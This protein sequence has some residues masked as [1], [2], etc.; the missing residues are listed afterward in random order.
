M[1]AA[2]AAAPM[3]DPAGP[4]GASPLPRATVGDTYVFDNPQERWTVVAVD[5]DRVTW[6]S[7][8]GASRVTQVDPLMPSIESA[9][10]GFG[11]VT[12]I[13]QSQTGALWPLAVGNESSFVVAVGMEQPPYS[14][15]LAWN[16]RVVGVSRIDVEA[17]TFNTHKVACAR[18]DG[19][20]LN[21]Y[22]APT[23]GYFVRREVTTADQQ[24]ETR[25]LVSFDNA[26]SAAASPD[27]ANAP[28]P[29]TAPAAPVRATPL[30]PQSEGGAS[31]GATPSAPAAMPAVPSAMP[32]ADTPSASTP[33]PAP[34]PVAAPAPTRAAPA[35]TAAASASAP[36]S[37][38]WSGAGVRLASFRSEAAARSGW[39]KFQTAYPNLLSGLS[40]RLQRVDLGAQG[41]YQR[42][43]AGPFESP[44]RARGLC[45]KIEEMGSVCDV[46][47]F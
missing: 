12:R 3:V 41:T 8:Q 37:G 9:A 11:Q 26:A 31:S 47:T 16:C 19:L 27:M 30:A 33:A 14:Q 34:A 7:D 1:T 46:K 29:D 45:G 44:Q 5:D 39:A 40:P 43:Y 25:S 2:S 42:L 10:P 38:G 6:E 22:Y 21:T 28:R 4:I 23:A 24:Q 35:A 18:S 13:I 17:G 36:P 20:R 32:P 15:S